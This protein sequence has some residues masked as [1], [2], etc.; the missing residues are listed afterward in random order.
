MRRRTALDV[1][2]AAFAMQKRGTGRY[3][4]VPSVNLGRIR[5]EPW[6][7][8]AP[9]DQRNVARDRGEDVRQRPEWEWS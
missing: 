2:V 6:G 5:A 8:V 4:P 1:I 3:R 9:D 7:A